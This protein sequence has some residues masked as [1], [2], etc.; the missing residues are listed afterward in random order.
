MNED[1][2]ELFTKEAKRRR[3][4]RLATIRTNAVLDK[5]RVLAH[6]ANKSAYSYTE[7]DVEKIFS[8]LED[9]I[10]VVKSRFKIREKR[11]ITLE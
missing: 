10:K 8:E 2:K 11:K 7:Q 9:E 6:C 3:F 4:V 1:K 5:L